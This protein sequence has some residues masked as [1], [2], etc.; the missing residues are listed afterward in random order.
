MLKEE[1][2]LP[3]PPTTKNPTRSFLYDLSKAFVR[4][5]RQQFPKEIAESDDYA[6]QARYQAP[7]CAR[8]VV[9]TLALDWFFQ[10]MEELIEKEEVEKG[11]GGNHYNSRM[12][13]GGGNTYR[14]E[15]YATSTANGEESCRARRRLIFTPRSLVLLFESS[16]SAQE[17]R[18]AL[19]PFCGS[20][21]GFSVASAIW[22]FSFFPF[23]LI[24]TAAYP[25]FAEHFGRIC[26]EKVFRVQLL[27]ST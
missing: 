20:L 14:P 21:V 1:R 4:T 26:F 12:Y 24:S 9:A 18:A 13:K 17:S 10:F 3:P 22:M 7:R 2:T 16:A 15:M 19:S 25:P 27:I 11:G 23:V 6:M 5:A 8:P